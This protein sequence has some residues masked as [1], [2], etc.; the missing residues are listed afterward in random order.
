MLQ[1]YPIKMTFAEQEIIKN[2]ISGQKHKI[3]DIWKQL[4]HKIEIETIYMDSFEQGFVMATIADQRD[5]VPEVWK[6]LY[7]L[8]TKFRKDAGVEI[9]DLGNNLIQLKD[10][11]GVVVTRKKYDWEK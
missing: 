6:Q 1:K 11:K 7:D 3:P 5:K 9:T 10:D 8:M 4:V 2:I